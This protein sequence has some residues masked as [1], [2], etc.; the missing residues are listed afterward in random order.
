ME[1]SEAT[2]NPAPQPV[3]LPPLAP[4]APVPPTKPQK[5]FLK[6]AAVSLIVLLAGAVIILAYQLKQQVTGANVS[7][8][9]ILTE[10][11]P[12]MLV[13]T[14]TP[15]VDLTLNWETFDNSRFGYFIKIPK[16]L[17]Y[18]TDG[19]DKN[20]DLIFEPNSSKAYV[21]QANNNEKADSLITINTTETVKIG[22]IEWKISRLP[23][24]TVDFG[25]QVPGDGPF[26]VLQTK[27]KNHLFALVVAGE[28]LTQEQEQ[29]LSTFQ[30]TQ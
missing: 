30:F 10:A 25:Y 4:T 18:D 1:N 16:S 24:R 20:F 17:A 13:A 15:S 12:S 11:S 7:V 19:N 6:W 29:I 26:Y 21:L 8:T 14:S 3:N 2:P 28:G 23:S 5:K 9:P 22:K 27:N